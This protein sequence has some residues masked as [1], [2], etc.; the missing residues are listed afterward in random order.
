MTR[1]YHRVMRIAVIADIHG[2]LFALEA[3]LADMARRNVDLTVN[4]GDVVSGPL[5]PAETAERLIPLGFPTISGNHERQLLTLAPERMS[6]SDSFTHARLGSRHRE[7][8]AGFPTMLDL[9]GRVLLCHGTP[10]SDVDYFLET[11]DASGCRVAELSEV[12]ERAGAARASLILCGHTHLPRKVTLSDGRIVFNPGSVGLQ[13]YDAQWPHP[14]V[15]QTGTPHA[16][17]ALAEHTDN[18]W[19]IEFRQVDYDWNAAADLAE[20]N[21]RPDWA[22][23]LRTGCAK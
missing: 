21:G 13:A 1:C 6:E 2:N 23:A 15:M 9:A 18:G 3:V 22:I 4:L 8:L 7:W 11:V 14:H 17:Y 19:N 16:R 12:A 5:Q 10:S 20:A